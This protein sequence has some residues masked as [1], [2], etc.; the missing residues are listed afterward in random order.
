MV[1]MKNDTIELN[2]FAITWE[3]WVV[4]ENISQDEAFNMLAESEDNHLQVYVNGRW[5]NII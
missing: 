4:K 2:S 3:G 5:E 1:I